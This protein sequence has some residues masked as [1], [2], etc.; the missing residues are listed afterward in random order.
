MAAVTVLTRSIS[1]TCV[2]DMAGA[3]TK[4]P[5][6]SYKPGCTPIG[7]ATCS[8]TANNVVFNSTDGGLGCPTKTGPVLNATAAGNCYP[9]T[10]NMTFAC[11][12]VDGTDKMDITIYTGTDCNGT[13]TNLGVFTRGVCTLV[14]T[15]VYAKLWTNTTG[16]FAGAYGAAGCTGESQVAIAQVPAT[17]TSGCYKGGF[18]TALSVSY[19]LLELP[20]APTAPPTSKNGTNTSAPTSSSTMAAASLASVVLAAATLVF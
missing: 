12:S 14:Y 17:S 13:A 7:F 9:S 6:S 4:T 10:G 2:D 19:A 1:S 18:L 15:G 20:P 5:L 8:S 16:T 3:G 11:S